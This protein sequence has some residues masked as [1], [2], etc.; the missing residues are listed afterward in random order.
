MFSLLFE[1]VPTGWPGVYSPGL[2]S[3]GG[4]VGLSA[5]WGWQKVQDWRWGWWGSATE[6]EEEDGVREH[7]LDVV[8][9]AVWHRP[10]AAQDSKWR[11]W[12]PT[13]HNYGSAAMM[14]ACEI[15]FEGSYD[16][17][18]VQR[19]GSLQWRLEARCQVQ[20]MNRSSIVR[21]KENVGMAK[22]AV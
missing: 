16:R 13:Y 12:R 18:K 19:T 4:W 11:W 9:S 10:P 3:V 21:G 1:E 2:L 14:G 6:K 22:A 20:P 17:S 7:L 15:H 8:K 5:G